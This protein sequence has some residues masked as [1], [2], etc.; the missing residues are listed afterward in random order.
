MLYYISSVVCQRIITDTISNSPSY[1]D[2]LAGTDVLVP[3]IPTIY[4]H[5]FVSTTLGRNV[6]DKPDGYELRLNFKSPS[7]EDRVSGPF[8]IRFEDSNLISRLNI[9]VGNLP[10]NETG[11]FFLHIELKKKTKWAE[12]AKVPFSVTQAPAAEEGESK[13]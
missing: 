12:V 6:N 7:G 13:E 2:D 3:T 11:V 4:P 9:G 5:F 8:P 1:I 10:I